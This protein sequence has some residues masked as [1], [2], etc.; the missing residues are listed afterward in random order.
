VEDLLDP[1]KFYRANR[2]C[3]VQKLFLTGYRS[4]D[5]GKL[6][7]QLKMSK[8]PQVMVSKDK[9]AAFKEWITP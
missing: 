7:L 6:N 3:I 5:T 8:P 1:Q 2:Q 4:D 9:A